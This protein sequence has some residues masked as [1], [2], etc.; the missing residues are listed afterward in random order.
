MRPLVLAVKFWA[1]TRH[2]KEA[3]EGYLSSYSYVLMVIN[4]LQSGV[5]P[6]VLPCLQSPEL[7]E[8]QEKCKVG[9]F[10]CTFCSN[11]DVAREYHHNATKGTPNTMSVAELLG[12]DEFCIN[13]IF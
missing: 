10:D 7:I 5:E 1:K 13:V 9:T 6:P 4:F 2:V 8:G 12:A 3:F 11:L